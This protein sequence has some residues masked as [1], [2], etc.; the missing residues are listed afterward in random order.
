MFGLGQWCGD[1]GPLEFK[2]N[3]KTSEKRIFHALGG[4]NRNILTFCAFYQ[5]IYITINIEASYALRIILL[6]VSDALTMQKLL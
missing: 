4:A 5:N 3:K 6:S 1:V 2:Y